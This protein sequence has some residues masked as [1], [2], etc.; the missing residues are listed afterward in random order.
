MKFAKYLQAESIPEW[1]SKYINYKYLKKL[2][3]QV[4]ARKEKENEEQRKQQPFAPLPPP[5]LLDQHPSQSMEL[6]VQ[7][8]LPTS[9]T[10]L[11]AQKVAGE[12][13]GKSSVDSSPEPSKIRR[14]SRLEQRP[15]TGSISGKLGKS[16]RWLTP[17]TLKLAP[18]AAA[19]PF[20]QSIIAEETG[21]LG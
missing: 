14:K 20:E 8:S 9:T 11:E 21:T 15:S 3:K 12:A 13:S 1:K 4:A 16:L 18:S 5:A 2:L 7:S 19:V 6:K 17:P 10:S